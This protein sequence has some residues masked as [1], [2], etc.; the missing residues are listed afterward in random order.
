MKNVTKFGFRKNK[1]VKS[2]C[3]TIVAVSMMS[4]SSVA[5][6]DTPASST[7]TD[8]VAEAQ[9]TAPTSPVAEITKETVTIS[10]HIVNNVGDNNSTVPVETVSPTQTV[11]STDT[12]NDI[13]SDEN[14]V[15]ETNVE[16]NIPSSTSNVNSQVPPQEIAQ[17]TAVKLAS[18]T[19]NVQTTTVQQ[20][21]TNLNLT[22]NGELLPTDQ[23]MFAVWTEN[24][25]QDDLRWYRANGNSYNVDLTANHNEYGKYNIHTYIS[26]NG[27]MS[28]KSTN[29]FTVVKQTPTVSVT[30]LSDDNYKVL[31]SNVGSDFDSIVLPIWTENSNQDDLHWYGTFKENQGNYTTELKIVNHNYESGIYNIHVYGISNI[32]HRME[33]LKAVRYNVVTDPV[34][35]SAS[36]SNNSDF[37]ATVTNVPTYIKEILLPTWTTSNNQDDIRWY[38]VTPT[39]NTYTKTISIADHKYETG[40]YNV[41]VYGKTIDGRTIGLTTIKA[42]VPNVSVKTTVLDKGDNQYEVTVSNVPSYFTSI[43]TPVWSSKDNQDDIRW[44]SASKNA[45]GTYK[46]VFDLKNHKNNI[47]NY[48]VHV[49][50]TTVNGDFR[51]LAGTNYTV[52]DLIVSPAK[53]SV[54]QKVEI[55][56]FA[57]NETTGA[58]LTSKR[59]WIGTVTNAMKNTSTSVGGWMYSVLYGN[60]TRNLNVL[61]QDLRVVYDIALKVSNTKE[62]N[63]IALQRAMNYANANPNVTLYLPQGDYKIGSNIQESDLGKVSGNEYIIL[64]SNTKLRGNDL[65][66]NLIVDGTML[67]FGLPTGIRG[68]DG[69]HDLVIDRINVRANDL[70]NGDYFMI[71][72]NHGNNITVKNSTFTMVQ[73]Q[74]RHIF[75]LGGVQNITIQN[76]KFYGYAPGLTNITVVPSGA[77]LHNFYA[78]TIQIDAS[79]NKGTWDASMISNIAYNAYMSYNTATSLLS[80]NVDILNNS[81]LPF[82]NNGR[83]VAYSSSVGQHSSQ[84][85][86]IFIKDNY[87][88][89]TLSKRYNI[90][91]W[92]M[93]PIHY[94]NASGYGAD[95]RNNTI[96]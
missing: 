39:G 96:V 44:Y 62:Q 23:L 95:V 75:D 59:E 51:G 68:I 46:T 47:G 63:N 17:M 11:P 16:T 77:D 56:S 13:V 8:A 49:Y 50:G 42:I 94:M 78:E 6:A 4:V 43:K 67:W 93:E 5:F 53:F 32:T 65:G 26:A 27:I 81:F 80:S 52:K 69:V 91:Q 24:N 25:S 30:K 79:N 37:T 34:K 14:P 74:S 84:V 90:N 86:N 10:D 71:M 35:A 48:N 83:L 60:G 38:S 28:G 9:A 85:G 66:T 64:A 3:G 1:A 72:L 40:E 57:T 55:Q 22:Y 88:E 70:I 20:N 2:L 36:V 87:F 45:D 61:E 19:P 21:A 18:V 92:I 89:K 82:Y 41:H 7:N 12:N 54:G 31:V 33:G 73:K 29:T 15:A 76:N 58:D